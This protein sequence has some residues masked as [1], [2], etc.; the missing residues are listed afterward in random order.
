M[1]RTTGSAEGI[2]GT[3]TTLTEDRRFRQMFG[4]SVVVADALWTLLEEHFS[5]ATIEDMMRA[6]FFLKSYAKEGTG[7]IMVGTI[8]EKTYR[9]RL[10]PMIEAISS[11]EEFVVN[12]VKKGCTLQLNLKLTIFSLSRL[13][14][15]AVS[16]GTLAMTVLFLLMEQTSAPKQDTVGSSTRT[17]FMVPVFGMKLRFAS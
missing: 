13:T 7:S 11:L 2:S 17:S 14:G 15:T 6:L 1:R 10:W 12:K 5:S 9:K 4:C 16:M 3:T 8:D